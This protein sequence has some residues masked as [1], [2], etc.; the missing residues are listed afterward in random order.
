MMRARGCNQPHSSFML[1]L[2]CSLSALLEGL[3]SAGMGLATREVARCAEIMFSHCVSVAVW[4]V[5][6]DKCCDKY[7][8]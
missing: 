4:C 5:G 7:V 1:V 8:L 6:C 3:H 2:A